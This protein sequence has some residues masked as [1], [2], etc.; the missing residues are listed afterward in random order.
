MTLKAHQVMPNQVFK[1]NLS[2]IQELFTN[3]FL[4]PKLTHV[5]LKIWHFLDCLYN[6]AQKLPSN[7]VQNYLIFGKQTSKW[8]I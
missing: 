6:E 8:C 1:P 5:F 7:I 2:Q 3:N 4:L